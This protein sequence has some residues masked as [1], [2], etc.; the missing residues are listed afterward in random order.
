MRLALF[1][2]QYAVNLLYYDEWDFLNGV[3]EGAEISIHYDPMI[4]K[5]VTHGASRAEAIEL[6]ASALDAFVIDGVAHNIPFLTA[7]MQNARWR[8]GRLST[9][10][11][12]EASTLTLIWPAPGSG[13][14]SSRIWRTFTSPKSGRTTACMW[15]NMRREI[16]LATYEAS[17]S[18]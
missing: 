10:F 11:I 1:V 12:A 6:Q 2:D 15:P 14:G 7:V 9:G 4:A 8:E 18:R 3:F 16:G 17:G 5:L 13:K